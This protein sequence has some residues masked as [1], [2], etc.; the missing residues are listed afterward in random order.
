MR[1]GAG[2]LEI[3]GCCQLPIPAHLC[4]Q[5]SLILLYELIAVSLRCELLFRA[6]DCG[7]VLVGSTKV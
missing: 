1:E 6:L 5:L 7:Q 4:L 3:A 2:V